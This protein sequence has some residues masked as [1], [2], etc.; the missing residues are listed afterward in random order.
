MRPEALHVAGSTSGSTLGTTAEVVEL[1]GPEI[2]ATLR[3]GGAAGQRI[4]ACLPP[5]TSISEGD[6][7][8]LAVDPDTIH[9]FDPESGR[10]LERVEA[11]L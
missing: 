11:G 9:L 6:P 4:V 3:L 10:S 7:C 8:R 2:V 5:R 1:T